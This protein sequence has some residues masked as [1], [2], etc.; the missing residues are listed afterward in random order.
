MPAEEQKLPLNDSFSWHRMKDKYNSSEERMGKSGQLSFGNDN[1]LRTILLTDFSVF[2]MLTLSITRNY[3]L[4]TTI[5]IIYINT[6]QSEDV[7]NP[8]SVWNVRSFKKSPHFVTELPFQYVQLSYKE[9]IYEPSV[10]KK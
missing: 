9:C 10:S 6:Y 5:T 2:E 1:T 3:I 8:W 7:S 4:P